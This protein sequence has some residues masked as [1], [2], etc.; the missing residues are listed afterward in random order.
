MNKRDFLRKGLT[1]L[2]GML[3]LSNKKILAMNTSEEDKLW[4]WSREAMHYSVTPKGIKCL[5]CP[6]EC[7]IRLGNTGTCRNRINYREKLYTIAYGNPCAVHVDPIE[8]KPLLHFLPGAYAYSLATAGCN[9][10]CLNCQNWDIS[11]SS[12]YETRNSDLMP[13]KVVQECISNQCQSIAYTYSEP[14]VFY[15]YMY[16]TAKLAR[17]K[18]IKNVLVSNGYINE[19]PL[20]ELSKYIDAANINLKSFSDDIYTR[21]N[22]GKL[23]PILNTLQILKEENVW[24]E[25]TNLIVPTWT[26]DFD[27][28]QRM[29]EWLVKNNL[30]NY[31][32]HFLRFHPM[33]KLTQLP[34]TPANTLQKA[35][36]IAVKAG[37]KFVYVGNVADPNAMNTYCP[38]CK[39]LLVDRMGYKVISNNIVQ[40]KCKKCGEEI[41]GV[42]S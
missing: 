38:K 3:F 13:E 17:E 25:I 21:L 34:A 35:K 31:P 9:L 16:E 32:L 28:I 22:A 11:Q 19:K 4:K 24:L 33:Y 18:K 39:T 36:E 26:D 41:P 40:N 23:Q 20:R 14:I 6:N 15:E 27:M 2:G 12:P 7:S 37:C 5:L 10:G 8:K 1:G 29:C 30:N 42:W